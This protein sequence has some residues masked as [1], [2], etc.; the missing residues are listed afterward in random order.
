[1]SDEAACTSLPPALLPAAH[2][3]GASLMCLSSLMGAV[4]CAPTVI[5]R[6][7]PAHLQVSVQTTT[8]LR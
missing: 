6:M 1:M 3:K 5:R 7:R 8:P 4:L 2:S